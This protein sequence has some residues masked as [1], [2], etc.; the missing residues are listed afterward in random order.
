MLISKTI[1]TKWNSKTKKYYENLGYIYTKMGDEF[2]VDVSDLKPYSAERVLVKCDYCGEIYDVEWGSYKRLKEK[3]NNSDCCWNKEC[4][5][6][7][8]VE[9]MLMLYGVKYSRELDYVNEKIKN[10]NLIKY[11]CENPFGNKEIQNKIKQHFLD[12][13]GVEYCMQADEIKNRGIQT[14]LKRYGVTSWTKTPE[15]REKMGGA[16]SPVW[17]GDFVK[18]ERTDRKKPEYRDWRKNVFGRDRYTCQ[19]C[20][21]HSGNGKSVWLEAHHIFNYKDYPEKRFDVDNGITLCQ[22]CHIDFHKIYGKKN[23]NQEQLNKFIKSYNIDEK[24]C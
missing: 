17:K 4:T 6:R 12:T 16:N 20:G 11:G 8:S 18:R 7:K 9:S 2:D 19:C 14:N 24:I 21:A 13:Y 5:S 15:Y 3:V 22:Q 10:T 1:K 23:N